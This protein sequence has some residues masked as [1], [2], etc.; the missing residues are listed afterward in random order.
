MNTVMGLE[1]S[2]S[3]GRI[4]GL[5]HREHISLSYCLL[6]LWPV[7]RTGRKFSL[8]GNGNK[9]LSTPLNFFNF[10]NPASIVILKSTL[11]G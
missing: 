1:I 5:T 8:Q 6:S 11:P 4:R 3:T 10:F 9:T 7:G 2:I